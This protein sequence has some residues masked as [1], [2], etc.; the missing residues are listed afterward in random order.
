MGLSIFLILFLSE[1][2]RLILILT[3]FIYVIRRKDMLTRIDTPL[4][5]PQDNHRGVKG[6]LI[7]T[8]HS[9]KG[10]TGKTLL[11]VNLAMNFAD[12]GKRV[13]LLDLD[14]RAPSLSS[15]FKNNKKYC[16]LALYNV[17]CLI[18]D[19]GD[20]SSLELKSRVVDRKH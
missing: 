8:L 9:Y 2:V 5:R 18:D 10:G 6:S 3:S 15:T 20:R 17:G 4:S 14:L 12:K 13:C 1:C 16:F 7:I 11:S 19:K